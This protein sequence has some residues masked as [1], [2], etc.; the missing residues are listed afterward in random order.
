VSAPPAEDRLLPRWAP[1]LFVALTVALIP[2]TVWLY[3]DLPDRT[4]ANHWAAAWVGFDLALAL[5]LGLTGLNILR[6]SPW[7]LVTASAAG[8]M[9]LVDAWFDTLT[10]NSTWDLAVALVMALG[11]EV[12]LAILCFWIA[13]NV[14]RVLK[15]AQRQLRERGFRVRGRHL[16][17]PEVTEPASEASRPGAPPPH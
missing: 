4:R 3:I 14:E 1:A 12:P 17:P 5:V 9:L 15:E 16:V 2:W 11:A 7:T 10:A 13:L 8:T 6:R